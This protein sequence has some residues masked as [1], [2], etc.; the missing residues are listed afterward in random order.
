MQAERFGCSSKSWISVGHLNEKLQLSRC[1]FR[2]CFR[3]SCEWEF[4]R[5]LVEPSGDCKFEPSNLTINW[6][7]K[8]RLRF[9]TG[10]RRWGSRMLSEGVHECCSRMLFN[11]YYSWMMF[12]VGTLQW[13]VSRMMFTNGV[14][15]WGY[16]QVIGALCED[17][18][19]DDAPTGEQVGKVKR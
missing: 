5:M 2:C 15:E 7:I 19:G 16:L 18:S 13:T 12:S 4:W 14:H 10:R 3:W 1:C 8:K 17:L 11:E 9:E 6:T